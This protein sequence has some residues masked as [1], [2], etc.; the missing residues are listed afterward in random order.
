M[1]GENRA[2]TLRE[3][4]RHYMPN[5]HPDPEVSATGYDAAHRSDLKRKA[6]G[7]SRSLSE[8]FAFLTHGTTSLEEAKK[9]LTI[10]TNVC[11][12]DCFYFF[13][14]I[15]DIINNYCNYCY[16]CY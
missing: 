12:H 16:Y 11:R 13:I 1:A 15:I 2:H 5:G 8:V 4:D 14:V 6:H 10:I 9:L 3:F 7:I